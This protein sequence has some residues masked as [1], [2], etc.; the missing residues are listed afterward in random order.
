[1]KLLAQKARKISALVALLLMIMCT[2]AVMPSFALSAYA[3][4]NDAPY[5]VTLYN[6]LNGL[7][8]GEANTV[9]QTSD[10]YIWIGSYG[11]L[12]RYDGTNFR[13]YSVEN[14]ITSSSV[15]SLFEDSKGR[16]WIGTNDAGVVMMEN[17]V[18][19]EIASPAD[20]T[21]LCIRGFAEDANGTIYIASN[22]G[23]AEIA[24]GCIKPYN[25]EAVMGNTVYCVAVDSYGRVW[26]SMNNG[27]CAIMKN[28][29]LVDVLSSDRILDD[30]EIYSITSDKNGEIII[31]TSTNK[32]A[33]LHL[34]SEGLSKQDITITT[35]ETGDVTTHNSINVSKSGHI[36]ASGINGL[37][38]IASD[39]SIT[40]FGEEH[41]AMSVNVAI[42]D[43]ENNLWLASSSFG[44]IKYSLGCFSSPNKTAGLENISVN[45]IASADGHRYIGTNTELIICDENWNRVENSLTDMFDGIR[46]RCV[47]ADS[48]DNIWIA[49]Y[50]D[51]AAVCYDPDDGSI[52]KYSSANGL[53]G[54][55]ARVVAEMSDG[56][57]VVGT[58]SG[59]SVITDGKISE[60]YNYNNGMS[61]P[62]V[63]CFAEGNNG[64]ILIGSDGDGIYELSN[65]KLTNH[66]FDQGLA[67]GVVL[68]ML[69]NSDGS[70]WFISAGSSLYY[71]AEGKF[72]RL[73]NFEKGAGSIFEFYD[74]NDMLW[75]LQNNG[76]IALN[77]QQLLSGEPTDRITYGFSHG[78]TGSLNANTWNWI[79]D[80]GTLYLVTRNG[81]SEFGFKGV[82]H[83]LP[84][85]IVNSVTVDG[86]TYEHPTELKIDSHAQRITIDF[87]A[88]SFTDT[89]EL[90][91]AYRLSGFDDTTVLDADKCGRV[92]YT[93]L[94]GGDYTFEVWVYDPENPE[95][96][97]MFT[98][99]VSKAKKLIEQPL[100]WIVFVVLVIVIAFAI[101]Y[102]TTRARMERIHRRQQEYKQ[103]VEQSLLT[104]ANTIDAKDPY[105]NGHSIRVAHYSRE[106][107]K[108]MGM[109]DEE[110]E[111]IYYVALLHD[112]GKIGVPD[113]ILNKPGKLTPEE[114]E[115]IQQHVV[116]GGEILKDF[117]ALDGISEGATYHHERFDG[118]GY[119]MGLAGA[120]IPLLARIIGVADTYDAMSSDRCYRK[121]L[122]KEKILDEFMKCAGSQFDPD[123]V[124]YI[125]EMIEDGSA[126][127]IT[128]K[129]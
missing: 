85:I 93:N 56:R 4:D 81:I 66:G 118:K 80:D 76:I 37:A 38:V 106:I 47:I 90:R 36:L 13:N 26:G 89:S 101:A 39:G 121:A 129:K 74:R 110:Q 43:Y 31:G 103:I 49:S 127:I 75:I 96:T 119:V 120:D 65:G 115:I 61:N 22:S 86:M 77:K 35:Y 84:K 94:P 60:T 17:N 91:L 23:M 5:V 100:F 1:M 72:T 51:Y 125:I 48:D 33:K 78:L 123:I 97:T 87:S 34:N 109:S 67:E 117:N 92:S 15:R 18:F 114:R 57:I 50:S 25:A 104:F 105:T 29:Q 41:N 44:V 21:F 24:D 116:T 14:K 108:R 28:G 11:G 59:F 95:I 68:R 71:W 99:S 45:A 128:D 113:N 8:T 62:S 88:L 42:A 7:P 70:G 73:T 124:P 126:P 107:A 55:K 2:A 83:S 79:D 46:I 58:Q 40:E 19:T 32:I 27:D 10:G 6:E 82:E 63:L 53:A 16:L 12:I 64:E 111:N 30:A 3:A 98:L 54:D 112:I 20:H 69:K 9:L 52:V 102:L 122:S